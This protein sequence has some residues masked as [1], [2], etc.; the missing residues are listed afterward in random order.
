MQVNSWVTDEQLRTWQTF[1][2]QMCFGGLTSCVPL[3]FASL[4]KG[5]YGRFCRS[6]SGDVWIE[7]SESLRCDP[8]EARRTLTHELIHAYL[9]LIGDPSSQRRNSSGRCISNRKP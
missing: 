3:A 4:A 8:N 1:I 2:D 7:I 5:T 6:R 9:Y